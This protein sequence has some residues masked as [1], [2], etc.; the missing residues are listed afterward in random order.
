MMFSLSMVPP[1]AVSLWYQDDSPMPFIVAFLLTFLT[2]LFLWWPFRHANKDLKT[3]EGFFIVALFWTVVCLYG[4]LPFMLSTAP[5]ESLTDAVFESVSGFTTSGASITVGVDYLSHAIRYYR[6]QLQLIG[7]MGIIVLAVAILPMLGIGGMQ[8]YR[9]ETPGPVK[10]SKLTPRITETAKTLWFIYVGLLII[11]IFAYWAAG[12]TLFEAIGESFGTVSTGGF[13][14]HDSSFA[15]YDNPL[16]E[17]I[18]IVFMLLGSIN[19]GLHFIA[20]K[21]GTLKHYFKDIETKTFLIVMLIGSLIA[22]TVLLANSYFPDPFRSITKVIFNV[23]SVATTTGYLTTPVAAW[24]LFLP[25]FIFILAMIGGCGGSTTGGIKTMRMMLLQKQGV[26]EM[27]RLIHPN[28]VIPIKFG[29]HVL[30]PHILEATWGFISMY[31]GLFI[32]LFLLL[33]AAGLDMT[34]AF[35]S[36]VAC[37]ANSGQGLGDTTNNFAG[38][39]LFSKWLLIFAMLLGRLEIFS[40]LILFTPG[41]WRK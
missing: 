25:Y 7:G 31:I 32:L 40:I 12:M 19:F 23:I 10:D 20:V 33:M 9:A 37:L 11:C 17:I 34:T 8:L 4:A 13:S 35:G 26:R 14:L 39:N 18:A 41:F 36:L 3:R 27:S 5:H 21:E 16:I 28:A 2:G 1:I 15:Y 38:L 29:D 6:Q 24:P 22:L 30:P